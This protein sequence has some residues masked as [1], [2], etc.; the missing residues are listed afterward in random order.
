MEIFSA[1]FHTE[2]IRNC[3]FPWFI[4]CTS[5]AFHVMPFLSMDMLFPQDY[6][7]RIQMCL[8]YYQCHQPSCQ[9]CSLLLCHQFHHC[10]KNQYLLCSHQKS[11]HTSSNIIL[12][13][14]LTWN[15]MVDDQGKCSLFPRNQSNDTSL[16][17]YM[18]V[19]NLVAVF[20][21]DLVDIFTLDLFVQQVLFLFTN[22]EF[23]HG[24]T[25]SSTQISVIQLFYTLFSTTLIILKN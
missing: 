1:V 19:V 25:S 10:R 6:W 13:C 17:K 14:G 5:Q 7:G 23:Y 21:L 8:T 16:S 18:A 22:Y 12:N 11:A 3:L 20:L 9:A 15:A 24:D 2:F 4:P